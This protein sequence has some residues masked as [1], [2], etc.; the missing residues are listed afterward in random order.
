MGR[1]ANVLA[2]VK[3]G[4]AVEKAE[5]MHVLVDITQ[6]RLGT[7]VSYKDLEGV[8]RTGL[9]SELTDKTVSVKLFWE[10]SNKNI[11]MLN[12]ATVP[13]AYLQEILGQRELPKIVVEEKTVR[14]AP[15]REEGYK[16]CDLKKCERAIF[17]VIRTQVRRAMTGFKSGT[18]GPGSVLIALCAGHY[19]DRFQY[20]I[21]SESWTSL[22]E[23]SPGQETP[24]TPSLPKEPVDANSSVTV[25][26]PEMSKFV[27]GKPKR[28]Y[29]TKLTKE[30]LSARA[31]A[32]VAARWKK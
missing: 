1:K 10:S 31:K 19:K 3:L 17:S 28:P 11:Y 14:V 32:A 23:P 30:Q 18:I 12:G 16:S 15:R 26:P 21:I 4:V 29:R 2:A 22:P 8:L 25:K 24:A 9:V 20:G 5:S 6:L 7:F 13:L 27:P